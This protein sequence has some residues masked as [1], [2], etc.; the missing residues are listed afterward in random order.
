MTILKATAS[1][2]ALLAALFVLSSPVSA[3]DHPIRHI[4][5][6]TATA[7]DAS[8]LTVDVPA[9]GETGPGLYLILITRFATKSS[10]ATS[11]CSDSD[12]NVY[13]DD[14][15]PIAALQITCFAVAENVPDTV[16]VAKSA[17][18]PGPIIA[19]VDV[20]QGVT[21]DPLDLSM[22]AIGVLSSPVRAEFQ[23][24]TTSPYELIFSAP[25]GVQL[26]LPFKAGTNG[27]SNRCANTNSTRYQHFAGPSLESDT[28]IDLPDDLPPDDG[29]YGLEIHRLACTVSALGEFSVRP[30]WDASVVW[31]VPVLTF[32]ADLDQDH[33]GVDF[34]DD[35]CPWTPEG[36]TIF[37]MGCARDEILPEVCGDNLSSYNLIFGTTDDDVLSGTTRNDLIIGLGGDDSIDGS[38]GND[39]IVG[40]PGN[41]ILKGGNGLDKLVGDAGNDSLEG[42]N[43]ADALYGGDEDDNLSGGNDNDSLNGGTGTDMLNGGNGSAD[44]C[45]PLDAG[46]SRRSCERNLAP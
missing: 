3:D 18:E 11:S 35:R 22:L 8:S 28:G 34:P 20:F 32:V 5:S 27:T 40:G 12:G 33:D 41:D 38:G 14:F 17:P 10:S 31:L 43:D 6:T 19:A 44:R 37:A 25:S 36:A 45:T 15:D 21:A 2:G 42:G 46:G 13:Q 23:Q 1:L 30:D 26:D 24:P 9:V 4:V 7:A 39:C 16:T 29:P